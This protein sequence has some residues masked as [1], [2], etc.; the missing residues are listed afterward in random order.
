MSEDLVWRI[1]KKQSCFLRKSRNSEL[2][3]EPGNLTGRNTF[4]FSGL[5][6]KQTVGISLNANGDI[7]LS[8]RRS[9]IASQSKVAKGVSKSTLTKHGVN[10]MN[11]AVIAI[12]GETCCKF[13]APYRPEL[14]KYAVAKYH[15]LRRAHNKASTQSAE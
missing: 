6:R 10:K 15:A 3:C 13:P 9:K 4:K 8:K 7:V 12:R 5:A 14:S 1:V 11:K 2:T